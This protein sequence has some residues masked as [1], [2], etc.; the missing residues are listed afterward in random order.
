VAVLE[1]IEGTPGSDQ[2]HTQKDIVWNSIGE[3]VARVHSLPYEGIATSIGHD[4]EFLNGTDWLAKRSSFL[5]SRLDPYGCS[6]NPRLA[7]DAFEVLLFS[8]PE[9]DRPIC[10]TYDDPK[11]DSLIFSSNTLET[12]YVID[13]ESFTVGHRVIDGIGRALYWGPVREPLKK[14]GSPDMDASNEIIRA[15]NANV[16]RAWKIMPEEIGVWC[17]ASEMFWLPDVIAAH[18]LAPFLPAAQIRGIQPKVE[19]L[20]ALLEALSSDDIPK[21][22]DITMSWL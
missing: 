4:P 22:T 21:A 19:K 6:I 8:L 10:L 5:V 2:L 11:P 15:Y 17:V 13:M 1:F 7:R 16:P 3:F 12:P 20:K 9:I 14:G 18:K